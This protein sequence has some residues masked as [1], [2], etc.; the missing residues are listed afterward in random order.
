MFD[1]ILIGI[2]VINGLFN[3]SFIIVRIL[4]NMIKYLITDVDGTLTDGKIYIGQAG[5]VMKA[6]SVKDGYAINGIL[7]CK[8]IKTIILTCRESAI[9]ENR[10][11]ELGIKDIYQ[12]CLNKKEALKKIICK[13]DYANCAYFGD[14]IPDQEC[15]VEIKNAGGVIG[16][17]GNAAEEIKKI[18]DY[19]CEKNAGDG[20]LREFSEW[21]VK[22][23][24]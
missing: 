23:Y 20:A 14:D 21:I 9:V 16:C 12:N 11:N 4:I 7:S 15:M 18:C 5:E 13:N 24:K 6:F 10:C 22:M 19:V 17:P 8:G 1:E 3:G 2:K